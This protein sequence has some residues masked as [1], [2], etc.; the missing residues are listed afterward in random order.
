MN[1]SV[2]VNCSAA[3]TYPCGPNKNC[4]MVGQC[5]W[6]GLEVA[7]EGWVNATVALTWDGQGLV[8]TARLPVSS[9]GADF[10]VI[11]SSYGWGPIPMMTACE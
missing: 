9:A 11:G 5:A 1:D 10:L 2:P 4:S 7:G 6:A 3:A 8:L